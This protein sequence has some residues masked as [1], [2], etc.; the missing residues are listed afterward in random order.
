MIFEM[1]YF[2]PQIDACIK[3][4]HALVDEVSKLQKRVK[5]LEECHI[6]HQ[7]VYRFCSN[8]FGSTGKPVFMRDKK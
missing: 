3:T 5:D 4:I 6:H 8:S 1:F 2:Q 7:D